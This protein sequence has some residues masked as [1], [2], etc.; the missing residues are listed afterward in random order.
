VKRRLAAGV[1]ALSLLAAAVAVAAGGVP[2]NDTLRPEQW[3]LEQ[4]RA[5]EAWTTTRGAGVVVAVVDSGVD[6]SHPDLVLNLLPG[7]T[8]H[9]CGDA[10]C[11]NG[12][13]GRTGDFAGEPDHGTHV[14][15]IIG[16]V[17][18][19]GFGVAGVAP[20]VRIL[21]INVFRDYDDSVPP[22]FGAKLEDVARGVRWAVDHG[23]HVINLSL[24]SLDPFEP[25]LGPDDTNPLTVAVADAVARGVVVVGA[26][27][28]EMLPFCEAPAF[29]DGVLCVAATDRSGLP[30]EYSNL[31][32]KADSN[33]LRAPGGAGNTSPFC[34]D[35]V[36]STVTPRYHEEEETCSREPGYGTMAGSSM[37]APH[38]AGVAALVRSLGCDGR[39]TV[40]LVTS[41]AMNPLTG[42]RGS[43]DEVYG[44]GI[45]DAAAAVEAAAAR[46]RR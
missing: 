4:V 41:T 46:C 7:I 14:S 2:T 27:G 29:A 33:A 6:L 9:D 8:F 42:A 39:T 38:V 31:P 24:G 23:A 30:T 16:A 32:I 25:L 18:N 45:V 26:A 12:S 20:G 17:A 34:D 21:P 22:G 10:G 43:Y 35:G 1:A 19:N 5:P 11:G 37:S 3:G 40:E 15:G 13:Y 36:L 44:H 28:N